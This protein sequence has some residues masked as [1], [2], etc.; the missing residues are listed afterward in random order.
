MAIKR[1]EMPTLS[2]IAASAGVSK[3]TVSVVLNGARSSTR[4][5][6][7]TRKRINAVARDLGYYP[8]AMAQGLRRRRI[9]TVGVLF[10]PVEPSV[11]LANPYA[12]GILQG[13]LAEASQRRCDVTLFSEPWKAD[14]GQEGRFRDGRTD[15]VILVAPLAGSQVVERLSEIGVRLVT[16]AYP[17]EKH[18]APSVDVDNVAGIR[19][20]VA[21]LVEQGHRRIAHLT[22]DMDMVSVLVRRQAFVEATGAHGI[23]TPEAYIRICRY[24]GERTEEAVHELLQLPEPPT[25][26]VAGNDAIAMAAMTAA[27]ERGLSVPEQLSVVGFDDIPSAQLVTPALTTVR[28]PLREIGTEAM[29]LLQ[30]LVEGKDVE[31]RAHLLT[32][33]L[34]VRDST[35]VCTSRGGKST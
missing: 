9:N 10:G 19:L 30:D 32:P 34:I 16:V 11:I 4:V 35:T 28:Q 23:S 29:R 3:Y 12:S 15:G 22:G 5:S 8:N 27:R 21:H 24:S 17:G 26:I 6:D 2:D 25:A 18:N 1:R 33:E 31:M 7:E 20:A 13:I 14:A